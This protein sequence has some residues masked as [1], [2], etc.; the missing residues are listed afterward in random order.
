MA[1]NAKYCL[2]LITA[3]AKLAP[4]IARNLVQHKLCACVNIVPGV[5]SVYW[6][7]D[8]I[9]T[10]DENLL[11]A[12]TVEEHKEMV[13]TKVREWHEYSVPE[14]IFIDIQSGN[15]DY[16]RWISQATSMLPS[17]RV[18]VQKEQQQQQ[19]QA[20]QQQKQQQKE[21]EETKQE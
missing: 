1:F 2:A 4:V 7:D 11:I 9:Q 16:L 6:W 20:Q 5:Q 18:E 14:V 17:L 12:K 21:E 13:I 15:S 10:D 19:Q 3:P 8:Q